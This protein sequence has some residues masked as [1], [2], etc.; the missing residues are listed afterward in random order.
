MK[1]IAVFCS[2]ILFSCSHSMT[3]PNIEVWGDDSTGYSV[4]VVKDSKE[5]YKWS[6]IAA[7]TVAMKQDA[8]TWLKT[9]ISQP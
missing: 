7:D 8:K 1:K 2:L 5:F 4:R 6:D 9:E 3:D